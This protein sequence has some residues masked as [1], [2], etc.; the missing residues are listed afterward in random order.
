MKANGLRILF[1]CANFP[2]PTVDHSGGTDYFQYIASL[3][4]KH[5]VSLISYVRPHEE[6]HV[7]S[8]K[9]LCVDLEV[10]SDT[11]SILRRSLDHPFLRVAQPKRYC[12]LHS[13]KYQKGLRAMLARR[14]FDIAHVEGPW[15]G[16]YMDMLAGIKIVLDEVDV[17]SLVAYRQYLNSKNWSQ[18]IYNLYEWAK[19][20]SYEL[21]ACRQADLVF[22][23]S[24]KD[25]KFLESWLPGPRVEVLP[26]W[27][28]GLEQL[29]HISETP[30][31]RSSLLFLGA[32]NRIRNTEA[33]LYF[34]HEIFPLIRRE[35][36]G[37]KFYVVGSSPNEKVRRLA[38]DKDVIVTG[39]VEDIGHYYEKCAVFVAPI[40][41]GGGIIVKV[42]NALAAGRPAV[43]TFFGNEGIQATPEQ[44]IRIADSP[45]G[46][47]QKTTE[48][49]TDDGLWRRIARNGRDFVQRQYNWQETM[50]GLQRAYDSLVYSSSR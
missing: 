8:M 22:T 15:M 47:A 42:L 14:E 25:K 19:T 41:V 17:H 1:V 3:R 30:A 29:S 27:F 24:D 18:R 32:M 37:A 28:E 23:R 2:Y 20:H 26:P 10:V 45:E 9:E 48:L 38:K 12:Y 4:E 39:Y 13:S 33:V 16:Q 49:L 7:S 50:Q 43:T 31:E 11:R 36:A 6:K 40:L 5:E 35:M 44:E 21:Q 34:Y 46:F